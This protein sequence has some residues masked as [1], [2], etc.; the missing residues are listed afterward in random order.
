MSKVEKAVSWAER[1]ANDNSHGYGWGGWGP[2]F[3]CSHLVIQAFEQAGIPLKS[4]GASYTGNMRAAA[5]RCGFKDVTAGVNLA[6]GAG[7]RRGDILLAQA[8]H[9]ALCTGSGMIV[10]ARSDLDGRPGDSSGSEIRIQ[11]YY[12]YPWDCVLRP[13]VSESTPQPTTSSQTA[14]EGSYTVKAGDTLYG[15]AV[16]HGCHWTDLAAWNGIRSPYIIHPGQ[17]LITRKPTA[18]K[19]AQTVTVQPAGVHTVLAGDTLWSIAARTMGSGAK[20]QQLA[21]ANGIKFPWIIRPG[22]IL[23]VPKD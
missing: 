19:P 14:Q 18:A 12:N 11:R 21:E 8:H 7:L 6:T 16:A 3:D 9:T 17:V 4:S 20:W 10:Q 1:I 2:D 5:L 22:Q 23:V 13:L 15:I